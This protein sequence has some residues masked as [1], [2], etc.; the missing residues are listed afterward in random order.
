KSNQLGEGEMIIMPANE[1][2]AL[3]AP[4]AFKMMLLMIKS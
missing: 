2:H 1:P 4:V 3:R